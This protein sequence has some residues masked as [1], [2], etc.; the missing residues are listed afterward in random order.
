MEMRLNVKE[1]YFPDFEMK[2]RVMM[3]QSIL[4]KERIEFIVPYNYRGNLSR[5]FREIEDIGVFGTYEIG[6][7]YRAIENGSV[8]F[9]RFMEEYNYALETKNIP[10]VFEDHDNDYL[11]V[12]EKMP[13][14]FP[15][16]IEEIVFGEVTNEGIKMNKKIAQLYMNFLT[17]EI[18]SEGNYIKTT[19]KQNEND[20][21]DMLK[22][23]YPICEGSRVLKKNHMEEII[24]SMVIPDEVYK[25][26]IEK[27]ISL[28]ADKDYREALS[29]F[30]KLVEKM[31]NI[32][33]QRTPLD[34]RYFQ[35]YDNKIEEIRFLMKGGI[36]RVFGEVPLVILPVI[37]GGII[38]GTAGVLLGSSISLLS[39][40]GL[41]HIN[42]KRS[43][44]KYSTSDIAATRRVMNYIRTPDILKHLH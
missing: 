25:Y 16:K 31:T 39:H 4:L 37:A 3:Y 14:S 28:R 35:Q 42:S 8:K 22:V 29:G 17:D 34:L 27:V 40:Y 20:I 32:E 36:Y 26:D 13:Y 12:S 1:I 33:E 11:I 24:F 9:K 2:S 38:G 21:Q 41:E 23:L 10:N 44:E 18:V 30:N 43:I 15:N 7:N 6:N 5:I 19:N